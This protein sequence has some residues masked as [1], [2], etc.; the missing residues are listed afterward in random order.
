MKYQLIRLFIFLLL[1]ATTAKLSAQYSLNVSAG[2]LNPIN[3]IDQT[4]YSISIKQ[5]F[6]FQ[7]GIAVSRMISN[8]YSH[9][10]G[11]SLI[12]R[13][14]NYDVFYPQ[15]NQYISFRYNIG[16]LRPYYLS[17]ISVSEKTTPDFLINTGVG[18]DYYYWIKEKNESLSNYPFHNRIGYWMNATFIVGLRKDFKINEKHSIRIQPLYSFSLFPI[19]PGI[20]YDGRNGII[21]NSELVFKLSWSFR[22]DDWK[23]PNEK[24]QKIID[25]QNK[26]QPTTKS[27]NIHFD[28]S[29]SI[30]ELPNETFSNSSKFLN[31]DDTYFSSST[32]NFDYSINE[33]GLGTSLLLG[34]VF[35]KQIFGFGINT[36]NAEYFTSRYYPN[37]YYS[38]VNS[39][40]AYHIEKV[41]LKEQNIFTQSDIGILTRHP[42]RQVNFIPCLR[43]KYNFI[44]NYQTVE[45]YT[46]IRGYGYIPGSN[47]NTANDIKN[48]ESSFGYISNSFGIYAGCYL[49]VKIG[50]KINLWSSLFIPTFK[51]EQHIYY[52]SDKNADKIRF[53]SSLGISYNFD[54]SKKKSDSD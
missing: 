11:V 14:L 3:K 17:S 26:N 28:W 34:H 39:F 18:L 37:Q 31:G 1:I 24:K 8:N 22:K 25:Q 30:Y 23:T 32:R 48:Q 7:S 46:F 9:E 20:E 54:L 6:G 52:S 50:E 43:F 12:D 19:Y 38:S 47:Y 29:R 13:Q 16:T 51:T 42:H 4:Y 2:Y 49:K 53:T 40:T 44:D 36:V 21:S 10:I 5:A 27:I 45:N 15:K 41:T 33:Y 35:I